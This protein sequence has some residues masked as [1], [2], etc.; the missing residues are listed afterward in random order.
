[1]TQ[2]IGAAVFQFQRGK[3]SAS[4]FASD[5]CPAG[6]AAPPA[7]R[8][9]FFIRQPPRLFYPP[10]PASFLCICTTTILFL[11]QSQLLDLQTDREPGR[12]LHSSHPAGTGQ[13]MIPAP[14]I[15][16]LLIIVSVVHGDAMFRVFFFPLSC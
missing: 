8:L 9:L 7:F 3:P 5:L 1:M 12:R 14:S 11:R 13:P 10:V 15:L 16:L 6:T 4:A 2:P